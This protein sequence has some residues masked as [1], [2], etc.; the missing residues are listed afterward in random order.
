MG[1]EIEVGVFD[2]FDDLSEEDFGLLFSELILIDVL[3]EFSSFSHFHDDEDICGCVEDVIEFDDV[4]V[5]D[6]FEYFEF[7]TDLGV[8]WGTLEIM[9]MFLS[10]CL[11]RI[12]M[13]TRIPV[14]SCLASGLMN[15]Y[16][17]L[18]RMLRVLWCGLFGSGRYA[19]TTSPSDIYTI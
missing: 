7:A 4:G 12:L 18:W 17:G 10:L 13:A 9:F 16:I 2:C 5:T 14:S 8:G 1:D 15:R 3:I 11:L 19:L 6:V